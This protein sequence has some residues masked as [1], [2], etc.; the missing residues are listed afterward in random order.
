MK[1]TEDLAARA[2]YTRRTSDF[3]FPAGGGVGAAEGGG[4][5]GRRQAHREVFAASLGRAGPTG[6]YRKSD[7]RSVYRAGMAD[8]R[9]T[10]G[11]RVISVLQL[12]RG[13]RGPCQA[14]VDVLRGA[15]RR[16]RADDP[17]SQKTPVRYR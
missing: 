16:R 17:L 5:D 15:L 12:R 1:C 6:G 10:L 8:I 13:R 3:S 4:P 11:R 7:L 14:N 9:V 2:V